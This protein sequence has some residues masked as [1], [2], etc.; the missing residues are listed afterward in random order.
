MASIF[1]VLFSTKKSYKRNA[2][3]IVTNLFETIALTK[4]LN[5]N[6]RFNRNE[7]TFQQDGAPPHYTLL[8]V[9]VF[10]NSLKGLAFY[11]ELKSPAPPTIDQRSNL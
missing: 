11:T 10:S 9:S 5:N 8:F 1:L 6:D 2:L 7:L 4:M 3:A